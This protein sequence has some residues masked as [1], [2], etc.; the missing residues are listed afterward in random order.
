MAEPLTVSPAP[1][2]LMSGDKITASHL[3]RD[4]YVYV[5]QSTPTQVQVHPESLERQYELRER[6]VGLG[7]PAHQVVVIDA[8]LGRSGA[9]TEG[10]L[11]IA[12]QPPVDHRGPWAQRR[13]CPLPRRA[14]AAAGPRSPALDAPSCDAPC[15]A[16]RVLSSTASPADDHA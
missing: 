8:D 7:W 2:L 5:R 14:S 9:R 4:A 16:A 15:A 12:Q 6:A 11:P 10:G 13:P 1:A 3:G